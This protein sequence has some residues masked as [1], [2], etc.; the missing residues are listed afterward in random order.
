MSKTIKLTDK[1]WDK[2]AKIAE[3]DGNTIAGEISVLVAEHNIASK[4][5]ERIDKL[6]E[7]VR[8]ISISIQEQA[9]SPS[10]II[11]PFPEQMMGQEAIYNVQP[12]TPSTPDR[13]YD[14]ILKEIRQIQDEL[15][16][17]D[18]NDPRRRELENK[19][20]ADNVDLSL[21]EDE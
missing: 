15:K 1:A 3:A 20:R 18:D 8:N 7:R 10:M 9:S 19:L 11:P 17:V 4:I 13:S 14:D 21:L 16:T 6:D 12:Q 2:L 5:C